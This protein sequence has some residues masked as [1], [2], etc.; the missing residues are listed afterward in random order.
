MD[1]S[2][3]YWSILSRWWAMRRREHLGVKEKGM[4]AEWYFQRKRLC[5]PTA[6]KKKASRT[7]WEQE[8]GI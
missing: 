4:E 1:P 7:K 2:G 8:G 3:R 6:E 5:V